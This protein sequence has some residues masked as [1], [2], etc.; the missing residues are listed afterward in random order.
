MSPEYNALYQHVNS[1]VCLIPNAGAI[2]IATKLYSIHIFGVEVYDEATNRTCSNTQTANIL[3]MSMLRSVK[4]NPANFYCIVDVLETQPVLYDVHGQIKDLYFSLQLCKPIGF[5]VIVY[6]GKL[7]GEKFD[8]MCTHYR[9]AILAH[10]CMKLNELTDQ[11]KTNPETTVEELTF[12][13]GYRCLGLTH[14]KGQHYI[15]Q[16]ITILCTEVLPQTKSCK[17]DNM[18][19]IQ[20]RTRRILAS[21]YR[22]INDNE[23]AYDYILQARCALQYARPSCEI[24]CIFLEEAKIVQSHPNEQPSRHK[25][26][27]LLECAEY[28]TL[29]C[30][31]TSRK[32]KMLPMIRIQLALFFLNP[33][34]Q[35]ANT[36]IDSWM[37]FMPHQDK[38][39]RAKWC[40]DSV[41]DREVAQ[42]NIYELRYKTALSDW[43]RHSKDYKK[44]HSL[45]QEAQTLSINKEILD[46]DC[47]RIADKLE[48]IRRKTG[49]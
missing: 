22:K 8:N 15:N 49:V 29:H 26:R 48:W 35:G 32:N 46:E 20:A 2:E 11:L 3:V 30:L 47:L 16:S 21:A 18:V 19:L 42:G 6:S 23:A 38:L 44:A 39:D 45:L 17:S 24:A 7:S 37:S 9:Q 13:E 31:D 4:A 28:C 43:Y 36:T 40:L 25:I 33:T 1:L 34:K 14:M 12:F 10:D 27:S 41:D 5:S